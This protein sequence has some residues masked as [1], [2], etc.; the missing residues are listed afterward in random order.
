MNKVI[1]KNKNIYAVPRTDGTYGLFVGFPQESEFVKKGRL[2]FWFTD[3]YGTNWS[4]PIKDFQN[5]VRM[6]TPEVPYEN[7][8][9]IFVDDD[10]TRTHYPAEDLYAISGEAARDSLLASIVTT[11]SEE[12]IHKTMDA[13]DAR[14]KQLLAR[15]DCTRHAV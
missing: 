8:V 10:P 13:F 6:W 7:D 1:L 12:D 14:V 2:H 5:T 4:S 11:L 15:N 9:P 3:C